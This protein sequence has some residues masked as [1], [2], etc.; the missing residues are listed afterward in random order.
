MFEIISWV[1]NK[2]TGVTSGMFSYMTNQVDDTG[3][4]I[5]FYKTYTFYGVIGTIILVLVVWLVNNRERFYYTPS[6]NME[7]EIIDYAYSRYTNLFFDND[8]LH[9]LY[10]QVS[11]KLV[12]FS[13]SFR[14]NLFNHIT[15][16]DRLKEYGFSGLVW[17]YSGYGFSHGTPSE[18]QLKKDILLVIKQMSLMYGLNNIVLMGD[19]LGAHLSLWASIKLQMPKV[20]LLSP[21]TNMRDVVLDKLP[22]VLFWLSV[23]VTEYNTDELM[24]VYNNMNH[25][26]LVLWSKQSQQT[27]LAVKM[28]KLSTY[29]HEIE[30]YNGEPIIEFDVI[31]KFILN[32]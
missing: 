23:W 4:P 16:L 13:H 1:I 31:R 12:I 27:H 9:G 25:K 15:V 6:K 11:N 30:Y 29:N 8:R 14:G 17:D 19:G 20:V 2:I 22:S 18:E 3:E 10:S 28:A 26:T 24:R 21:F 32:A 7:S 5:P